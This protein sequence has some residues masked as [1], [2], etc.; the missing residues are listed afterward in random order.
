M[1]NIY[2]HR[3]Y[4]SKYFEN[5]KQGFEACLDLNITGIELDVQLT[6]DKEVVVIH[7]EYLERLL[8]LKAFVKDLTLEEL[9][10][11][12][13]SNGESV[14]TLSEYLDIVK[15]SN[16][17]TNC[18]LKTSVFEY[19]GIE[20]KVYNLFSEYNMLDRLLISSF[21]HYS[22]LRFKKISN[23]KVAALTES[24]IINPS[25]YL[26]ENKIEIY[27]PFF[28]TLNKDEVLKLHEA[29]IEINTW[30]VNDKNSYEKLIEIGVDG[31]I[32]N[33]PELDFKY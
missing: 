33:Y 22:L 25:K 1:T 3:G 17:I 12:K 23:L 32:T 19:I 5:S 14:I 8:N 10:S 7:D 30:T 20:E 29:G 11:Y 16:L 15:N 26:K 24:K 2:A 4:S 13:Y 31:I 9:K 27:H 21:N 28:T 18:E 6:K